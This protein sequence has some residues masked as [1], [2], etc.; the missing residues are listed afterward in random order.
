MNEKV[1][2]IYR[3]PTPEEAQAIIEQVKEKMEKENINKTGLAERTG[4][5]Y[6]NLISV[7]NGKLISRPIINK[8]SEW[9]NE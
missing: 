8:L 3:D 5:N 1:K 6:P 4:I 7:L 2:V 9:I